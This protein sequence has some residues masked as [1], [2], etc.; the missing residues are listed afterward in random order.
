MTEIASC[1]HATFRS[2]SSQQ[3][4]APR[5][6]ARLR[7]V[8]RMSDIAERIRRAR[9]GAG[10]NQAEDAA[11]RLG[12]KG[13]AYRHYE[14]GYRTPPTARLADIAH[15]FKVDLDWL[16]TGK[17]DASDESAQVI[18]IWSHIPERNK[19]A[20]LQMLRGLAQKDGTSND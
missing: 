12:M 5:S 6:S 18:D 8:S 1:S 7:I 10:F 13:S 4:F 11:K 20:A 16:L 19:A 9:L 3:L 17:G 2:A 14:S 15:L